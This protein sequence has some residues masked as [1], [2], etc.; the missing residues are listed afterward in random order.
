MQIFISE[1]LYNPF[2]LFCSVFVS[3]YDLLLYHI[4]KADQQEIA[5]L[6]MQNQHISDESKRTIVQQ[7]FYL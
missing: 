7:I 5:L 3:D 4:N 2:S 6:L 1:L